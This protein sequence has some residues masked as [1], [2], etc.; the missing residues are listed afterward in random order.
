MSDMIELA[1]RCEAAN[2]LDVPVLKALN[3]DILCALGWTSDDR[4]AYRPDGSRAPFGVPG[5]VM[6]LDDAMTLLD[7]EWGYEQ[8]RPSGNMG[9]KHWALIW[10]VPDF[11]GKA[12]GKGATPAL[13]LTAA[14]L[15]ARHALA[16]SKGSDR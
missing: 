14:A 15:R 9:M 1:V 7:D 11:P 12:Q 10:W 4:D 2:A 8:R 16:L 3:F 5:Y 13:A 6:S